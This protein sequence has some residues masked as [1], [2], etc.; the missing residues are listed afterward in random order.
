[1]FRTSFRKKRAVGILLFVLV[2]ALFFSFNRFPKLD[3][4]GEDLDAVTAPTAQCFQGYC[5][6]REAG[7]SLLSRWWS[8]SITYMRLVTVGMTFA[9]VVAGLAEA[10]LF[11][12]E[13]NRGFV[14]GSVFTRTLKGAA[15]G[16][17]MNLCSACIVPVS[18]A[19]RKRAGLEG[20]IAMVQGSATM[21]IPALAMAFF[22]FTPIL[23]FSRLFLAVIGAL[24][25]GPIVVMTVRQTRGP[26]VD[27]PVTMASVEEPQETAAWKPVLIEGFRHWG[28]TSIGYLVR[29][30]PIMVVA[31]FASG[32]AIQ[33]LSPE[34]IATYLGNDL[35][36][37]AIAATLGIMINVPLLFEIPLVALL[38]LLGMGTAPA[39]TLLFAAAAG[40]PVTFWGLA[41]IMPRRAIATFAGATWAV[42][43]FG[44]LAVLGI[45]EF[46]W[47][48]ASTTLR[49]EQAEERQAALAFPHVIEPSLRPI[50]VD[51][52]EQAGIEFLHNRIRV[53]AVDVGAGA[54]VLDFNDDGFQ[55]IYLTNND[56]PNAL[57]RNN[58]DGTF[59][60]VALQAGVD[61]PGGGESNGGC[62]ADYDN[63][64]DQDL[65]VS[66]FGPSRLFKNN[67]DGTF[68]DVALQGLGS[69][70]SEGRAMGCAWGDY[71]RD[72]YLDLAIV[73]HVRIG[74]YDT[75]FDAQVSEIR[76]SREFLELHD[77]MLLYHGNGDGTF[78]DATDL[79]GDP[80]GPTATGYLGSI[81][82]S[83]FQPAWVDYDGDEDPDLYVV[84]DFGN[85]VQPN[86]LWRNDGRGAD[87]TWSFVDVSGE[88]GAGVEMF[89]RGLAVGDYNLDGFLDLFMTNIGNNVLLSNNGY[90]AGFTN[91]TF[92]A[93]SSVGRL[94]DG[95]LR[96]AWSTFFFD[97]D[98]DRDEDLYV[99]SGFLNAKNV[100]NPV[101]QPN[102]LLRNDGDGTFTD[103]SP[104]SGAD[105]PGIGRG[106]VYL[107]YDNDGC[108]D[109]LVSNLRGR[110]RL[111]RNLCQS[112]SSWLQVQLVGTESN[113]DGV[114]AR[115]TVTTGTWALMRE[116]AA[117]S[118]QMG[119]NMMPA[120]FG[121][122]PAALA[123]FV[124]VRWPSGKVQTLT[125][126]PVNQR[127]TVTEPR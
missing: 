108:L 25:I 69:L 42:G 51:V 88:S 101:A 33:W 91:S 95:G 26:T 118:S 104:G 1:M 99:V 64:G 63:D 23:G 81:W 76:R 58:G 14:S 35:R 79:L 106:G 83:G 84:N 111:L 117:G 71:D 32:L 48:G 59:T 30:G 123:D 34:T 40:G 47:E 12:P 113:R 116:T 8:F 125:H 29:M 39:A 67:G 27:V 18:S 107:D 20:A 82:G 54:L 77:P 109:I 62:A 90:R 52:T 7:T 9:F 78:T 70:N 66:H 17:V 21:N 89:G 49:I 53:D 75:L 6:E 24:I 46:I 127:I 44:G 96:V 5:I 73:T 22:V 94:M 120:H 2:L 93:G 31:G 57:Y 98:N 50:F 56:G 68:T 103:V 43:A 45:G 112:G 60:D 72:G 87:G 74:E 92:E 119:Q 102:V 38:L 115:V 114:G 15:A 86:V 55:D 19:F 65:F 80:S 124:I 105:D 4:I 61:D 97:Y 85:R 100:D 13:S 16:P 10:F 110:A 126:V 11:P 3:I 121:L 41:K 122:G 28:K 36:G 37:I